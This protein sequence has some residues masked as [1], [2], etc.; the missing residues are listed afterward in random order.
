MSARLRILHLEDDR[1][2][3]LLVSETLLAAGWDVEV[4]RVQSRTDYEAALATRQHDIVLADLRLPG[5]DGLTALAL[6]QKAQH[7][8]PFI[9]LSGHADESALVRSL[10]Q[11][12]ADL[13]SKQHLPRLPHALRRV[14]HE[15]KQRA[16]LRHTT[17]GLH[18]LSRR[19]LDI[20]ETERRQIA[21]ELHDEV[22]QALTATKISLQTLLRSPDPERIASDLP[23]VI[24]LVDRLLGIVRSLSLDLRPPLLDELG[25]V[26]ALRWLVEKQS[27]ATG[28]EIAFHADDLPARLDPAL[29]ITCFRIAQESLT[30]AARHAQ[31]HSVEL[32]LHRHE[33]HL[34]LTIRDDGRGFV[35]SQAFARAD[36]G[37]SLGLI[38]M[39]ERASLLAG[40]CLID[41]A[42]GQGTE[43]RANFPLNAS[44]AS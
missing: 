43:I 11:G 40:S 39:Q 16:Q 30:N 22:G 42:P 6:H 26:P 44:I 5:F 36:R 13:L 38:S 3:S 1:D 9:F 4:M 25:L 33:G 12:A 15:S 27:Q 32:T 28:L 20:Q 7:P 23:E 19:L 41:S 24:T 31:A 10:E 17:E 35:P 2:D 21:R 18:R 37:G 14:L 34:Q 8:A 29:A